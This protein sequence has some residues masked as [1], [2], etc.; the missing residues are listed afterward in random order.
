MPNFYACPADRARKPGMT[1]YVVVIGPDTAFTPDFKPLAL[2]DFT[3]GT[4]NTILLGETRR[5]IPW[6]KPEDLYVDMN[7][8]L[9]GLG[10]HHGYHDNGF[11]VVFAD[12]SVRFLKSTIDP[13]VL[14]QLLRRN[15]GQEVSPGRD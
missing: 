14:G 2:P 13:N 8:P 11:N 1:N 5:G 9:T 4:S 3:N 12:G 7:V 10:S 6:T 15:G